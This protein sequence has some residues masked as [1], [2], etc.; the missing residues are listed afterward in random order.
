[1]AFHHTAVAVRDIVAIDAFYRQATGFDLVKVNITR[2][3]DGGFSKHF[4]YDAGEGELMAFWELHDDSYPQDFETGLSRA[5]GLPMWVNHYAFRANGPDD[6]QK[7]K[8]RW[9]DHGYDVLEANHHFCYSIYTTDPNHTL[10]EFCYTTAEFTREDADRA[11][12][13]LTTDDL[14]FDED[15]EVQLH[16]AT[17]KPYHKRAR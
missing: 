7:R 9:L 15:A 8:Q 14:P 10:V 6:I 17:G 13:A 1:M 16:K 12:R 5:A 3:P 11:S 4:F 2:T